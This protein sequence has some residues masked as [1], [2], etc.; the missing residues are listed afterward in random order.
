[1]KIK[2]NTPAVI[3]EYAKITGIQTND[4]S[5]II[6]VSYGKSTTGWDISNEITKQI[7]YPIDSN[8]DNLLSSVHSKSELDSAITAMIASG[9][10]YPELTGTVVE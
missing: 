7:T 2:L 5:V 8:I 3:C 9:T 1:M 4:V 10:M 6:A